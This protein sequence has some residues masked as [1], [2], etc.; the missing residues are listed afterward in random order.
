MQK[1]EQSITN[2]QLQVL[3][4]RA[5]LLRVDSLRST[6]QAGSGHPT[7]AL[8]AA[9]IMSALFFNTMCF[10]KNNVDNAYND[11]F[12]LSKGHAAPVLYAVYKQ[13]GLISDD[14]LM[15]LRKFDSVIEGHPTA[16]FKYAQAATGSL[17]Q[18]LSIG[19]GIALQAKIYKKNYKTYVLMGDSEVAEGSIWEAAEL[20]AYYKLNNLIA[21]LDVNR[22]G[23]AGQTLFG[24]H[25]EIYK[26]KFEAFGF[27]T[28]VVDGHNMAEL[29]QA[30]AQAQQ[31]DKPF[32]IIAKTIKGYGLDSI[33][34][35]N[36]YHGKAFTHEEL[37]AMLQELA[38]KFSTS[39]QLVSLKTYEPICTLPNES[40]QYTAVQLNEPAYALGQQVATR[41]AYGVT[42]EQLGAVDNDVV[43]LDAEVKNSTYAE[44]FE[45][46]FPERF[47]ECFVAEQNMVSMAVGFA[48]QGK[49]AFASTFGAFFARAFDQIRM[50]AI[51]GS[52]IKLVGSHAGVSI[53][54]DGPSQMALEDIALMRSIMHS[55]VFYPSDAVSTHKIVELMANYKNISYLR[56]TRA[57]TPVLYPNNESFTIGGFKILK[58]SQHD[59]VCVIAAG[60][61]LFEALKAYDALAQENIYIKIVDL[62]C[63]KP[64]NKQDLLKVAQASANTVMI[65]EDHYQA[66]GIG[67]AVMAELANESITFEHLS[68]QKMPRSGKPEELLAFEEIDYLTIISKIKTLLK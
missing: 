30:L 37:P 33:A 40:I 54:Q 45:K 9:D 29:V 50:A 10:D 21:I 38:H 22:L 12:I 35:K 11:R 60:I 7:S 58:E 23:Q 6:T 4:N 28:V 63:I 57:A 68:V 55:V 41:K 16:R 49:K 42:L 53:G 59:K 43:C 17:G 46:S 65:V 1:L 18:G 25:T 51:G 34:N 26:K 15:S 14:E 2:E 31:T 36:G 47:V 67:E 13:L 44:I 19:V 39:A 27:N 66:G 24:Y 64:L 20:A 32:I 56:T 62:Y 48:T 3:N 8:S 61:T 5:Y 52:S